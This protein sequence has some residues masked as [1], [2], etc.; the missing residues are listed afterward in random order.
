MVISRLLTAYLQDDLAKFHDRN[1]GPQGMIIAV[2]GA[3]KSEIALNQ[4]S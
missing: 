2:V 4:D 3:I 1:Y